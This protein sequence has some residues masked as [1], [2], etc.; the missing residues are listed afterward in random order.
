MKCQVL[1]YEML[2]YEYFPLFKYSIFIQD[3]NIFPCYWLHR[4]PVRQPENRINVL[5]VQA[6]PRTL[7]L[8]FICAPRCSALGLTASKKHRS[9]MKCKPCS[10]NRLISILGSTRSAPAIPGSIKGETLAFSIPQLQA[11]F[12][13]SSLR[14]AQFAKLQVKTTTLLLKHPMFVDKNVFRNK[15]LATGV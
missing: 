1:V 2:F 11:G 5:C 8:H 7:T 12:W 14:P 9:H 6:W 3:L 10:Q 4:W 15:D 13:Q